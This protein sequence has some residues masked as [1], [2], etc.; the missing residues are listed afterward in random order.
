VSALASVPDSPLDRL[1]R[2]I[3][4]EHEAAE[5]AWR[6]AVQ[7]AHRAGQRLLDAK[8]LVRHGEWLPWL[9][10][11]GIPERTAQQY[12]RLARKYADHADLP[13]T[14]AEALES[15]GDRE[16][17][18]HRERMQQLS[19]EFDRAIGG[20]PRMSDAERVRSYRALMRAEPDWAWKRVGAHIEE[21]CEVIASMPRIPPSSRTAERLRKA[22][23]QI[24]RVLADEP[25]ESAGS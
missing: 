1:A 15:L 4:A 5:R 14:I 18:A 9:R 10:E 12:M 20:P 25:E 22:V 19:A 17:R 21:F 3:R 7:H 16:R 8:A 2:E 13:A 11:I 23:E 6:S 24:E